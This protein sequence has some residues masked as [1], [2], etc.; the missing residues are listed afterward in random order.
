MATRS[1]TSTK[2]ASAKKASVQQEK[3]YHWALIDSS[4]DLHYSNVLLSPMTEEDARG[5]VSCL[6]IDPDYSPY[7]LYR[8]ELVGVFTVNEV[9]FTPAVK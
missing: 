7:E 2:K 8:M 4:G 3:L 9:V 1:S 6:E 5:Q